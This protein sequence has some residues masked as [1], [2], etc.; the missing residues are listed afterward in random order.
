VADGATAT[1]LLVGAAI[2]QW[3]AGAGF[4][5]NGTGTMALT[6]NST[7][8]CHTFA[9]H[10]RF[11]NRCM[12]PPMRFGLNSFLV[13]SSFSNSDIPWIET[14]KSWGADFV[15]LAVLEPAGLDVPRLERALSN[16][17]MVNNPVCGM[18]PPQHDLRGN[19]AQQ[20]SCIEYTKQLIELAA[21][22]GSK[23]IAGPFYSSVGRCNMHDEGERQR[24]FDLVAGHLRT[25][26]GIAEQ[27]GVTIA[28]EPLNRFETDFMNTLAQARRMIEA[29]GS[30]ALKIHADT[31]HMHIEESHSPAAVREAGTLV[32]HVHASANHRGV[33]GRDQVDWVGVFEALRDINYTGDMAIET[34]PVDNTTIARA[35]SIWI[36]RYKTPEEVSRAGLEFLRTT[37][38]SI[39]LS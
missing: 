38:N 3:S 28:I 8:P 2:R 1:D 16:A 20:E 30:P 18:F 12:I 26:T 15:E 24:Q 11:L 22:L 4:T 10:D 23:T 14:F 5:K 13:T 17:G 37:W 25:L 21:A 39:Q 31:F 33:P 29:V 32:G 9:R 34:F 6:G 27:A 19:A 35:A 7:S 36:Q